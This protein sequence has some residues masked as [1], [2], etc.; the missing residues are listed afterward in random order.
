M[1]PKEQSAFELYC[2]ISKELNQNTAPSSES[3]GLME[4]FYFS[5]VHFDKTP[6]DYF[7]YLRKNKEDIAQLIYVEQTT[8]VFV[9]YYKNNKI[10]SQMIHRQSPDTVYPIYFQNNGIMY[11]R[12]GYMISADFVAVLLTTKER[13]A[14]R[15]HMKLKES[16]IDIFEED[17]DVLMY[18]E[19]NYYL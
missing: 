17:W 15:I 7:T 14:E 1:I 13:V 3:Y 12:E 19:D 10:V 2:N 18:E 6:C 4:D 9:T 11:S 8:F 16:F 5:L